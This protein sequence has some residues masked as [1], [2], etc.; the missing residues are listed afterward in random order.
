[1]ESWFEF[2]P[3]KEGLRQWVDLR[4]AKELAKAFFD[5]GAVAV[6]LELAA[7]LNSNAALGPIEILEAW[8]EHKI[9]LDSFRG[10]TRNAD[11]AALAHGPYGAVAVTVE[12]RADEPFG[13]VV[14]VSL[15]KVPERSNLPA[16][17]WDL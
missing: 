7:L 3:P 5:T 13:D 1:V 8:P 9:Q 16:R 11:L 10:E 15:S 14:R 12:A 6:P 17:I 4:S 2:A